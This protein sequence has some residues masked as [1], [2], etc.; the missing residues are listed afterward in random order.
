MHFKDKKVTFILLGSIFGLLLIITI[1]IIII[2]NNKSDKE[3]FPEFEKIEITETSI[4]DVTSESYK[5]IK[6]RLESDPYFAREAMI[7]NYSS[8]NYTGSD[9]GKMI[10]NFIFSYSLKNRKYMSSYDE[11]DGIFCMNSRYIIDAFKELYDANISK[12]IDNFRGYDEYIITRGNKYCFNFKNVAKDYNNNLLVG[13]DAIN[14]VDSVVTVNLYLYEFYTM[15]TPSELSYI[16]LVKSNIS[17]SNFNNAN[18]I[19]KNN[20]NGK[21]THKQLHFNILNNGKHFKYQILE[22]KI[23]DY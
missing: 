1:P 6:E 19:V 5:N 15:H 21:V 23:L 4:E 2:S 17:N 18:N 13:V 9:L 3:A 8:N 14:V 10:W 12:E 22:S 16:N 7:T 20:L 11:D